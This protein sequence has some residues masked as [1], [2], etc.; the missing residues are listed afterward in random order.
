MSQQTKMQFTL[1]V[2]K[3]KAPFLVK[4]CKEETIENFIKKE[5]KRIGEFLELKREF[6]QT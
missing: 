6:R 2:L 1:S 3:S 5:K 4:Q